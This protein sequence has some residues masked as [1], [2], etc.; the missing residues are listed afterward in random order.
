MLYPTLLCSASLLVTCLAAHSQPFPGNIQA[1]ARQAADVQLPLE[2]GSLGILSAPKLALYKPDGA[3][4]FPAVVLL[5]QCGGLRSASGSWQNM[6]VLNW[7]KE[8]VARGYV[9]LVL[10]SLGPRKVDQLCYGV[11]GGVTLPRGV[12]DAYLAEHHLAG[13]PFIDPDRIAFVGFS[14]GATVGLLAS[15][16]TWA[17]ALS[18]GSNPFVGSRF[19]AVVAFYP[20]CRDIHQNNGAPYATVNRDIDTPLLVLMGELDAETP[21]SECISGLEAAKAAGA[22]VMWENYVGATHCWDCQNLDGFRKTDVRGTAVQ[23]LYS[24][25]VTKQSAERMFAFLKERLPLA[26]RK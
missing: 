13:I 23:Y 7:A 17:D 2:A 26:A 16:K 14:W 11:K 8:A 20:S 25:S 9:A 6:S 4:P 21:P 22:P 10:D 19:R 5:H 3:G 1:G 24:S 15:S 12:R 18:E